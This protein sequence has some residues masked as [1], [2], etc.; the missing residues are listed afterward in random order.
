MLIIPTGEHRNPVWPVVIS[1]S[2]THIDTKAICAA[3]YKDNHAY[4]GIDL[5]SAIGVE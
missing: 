1:V 2:I 3:S 5:A 4:L